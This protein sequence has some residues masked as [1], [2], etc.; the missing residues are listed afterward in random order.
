M[1][2]STIRHLSGF[3]IDSRGYA[4]RDSRRDFLILKMVAYFSELQKPS[5]HL[6]T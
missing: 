4:V 1:P 5:Q 6:A 3:K 2:H